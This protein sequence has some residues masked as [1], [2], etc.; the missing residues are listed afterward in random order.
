MVADEIKPD[1]QPEEGQGAFRHQ[2]RLP[3][4]GAQQ[5]AGERRGR[6]DCQRLAKVPVGVRAG[7]FRAREPVRQQHQHGGKHTAFRHAEQKAHHG[8]FP[9][10]GNQSAAHRTDAP[11][12]QEN[13]DQLFR[14]PAAGEIAAGNLQQHVAE[15]E[16]AG[17]LAFEPVVHEQV[18]HHGR[19]FGVQRQRHVRAVHVR[20]RVHDERDGDDAQPAL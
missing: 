8:K 19:N 20:N 13:G 10:T 3:A 2:H 11:E 4:P 7:A 15:K 14:A 16:N 5:P 1:R 17:G 12:H 6:G 18:L 9:E